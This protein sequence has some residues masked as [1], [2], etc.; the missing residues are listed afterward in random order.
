MKTLLTI[1]EAGVAAMVTASTPQI[2]SERLV[3][4]TI[5]Q[6]YVMVLEW[7]QDKDGIEDLKVFYKFRVTPQ[8]AYTTEPFMYWDDKNK[9]GTYEEEEKITGQ[10]I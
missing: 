2:V 1:M 5:P 8:G 3:G 7:D 10:K 9:N 4:F 6:P